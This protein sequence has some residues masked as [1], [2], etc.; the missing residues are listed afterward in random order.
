MTTEG[1]FVSR[2]LAKRIAT[3]ARQVERKGGVER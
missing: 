1:R 3:E 2:L